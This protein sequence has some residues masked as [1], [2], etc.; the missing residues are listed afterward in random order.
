[1]ILNEA[2]LSQFAAEFAKKISPGERIGLIGTLG[3]GKTTFTRAFVAALGSLD[4]VSS[5]TYVLE[6]RYRAK[7]NIIICHWDLYRLS[8]APLE[9]LEA[10]A[11]NEIQ[12][13]EW[14]DKFENILE[15]CD[16]ILKLEFDVDSEK[17]VITVESS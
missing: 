2:E 13:V 4:P 14:V 6:H 16:I 12:L 1:M 15:T 11:K 10:P 9:L 3:A 17:R 7:D 8:A 5:P